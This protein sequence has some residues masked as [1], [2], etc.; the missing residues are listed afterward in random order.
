MHSRRTGYIVVRQPNNRCR[1]AVIAAPVH[2]HITAKGCKMHPHVANRCA[3]VCVCVRW[4]GVSLSDFGWNSKDL[5][6]LV[7][8]FGS[9]T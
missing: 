1:R 7:H 5:Q 2:V 6:I 3:S 4:S 8:S 9:C